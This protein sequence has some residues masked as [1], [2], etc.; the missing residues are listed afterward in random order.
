MFVAALALGCGAGPQEGS[1][2]QAPPVVPQIG[3]KVIGVSSALLSGTAANAKVVVKSTRQVTSYVYDDNGNLVQCTLNSDCGGFALGACAGGYCTETLDIT[4]PFYKANYPVVA[5]SITFPIPCDGALYSVDVFGFASSGLIAPGDANH[6]HTPITIASTACTGSHTATWDPY[7]VPTFAVP[8]IYV[9]LPPPMDKFIVTSSGIGYPWDGAIVV[10]TIPAL[11]GPGSA[12]GNSVTFPAPA[13]GAA[14][15][16]D[17]SYGL[18]PTLVFASDPPLHF[19]TQ[20][21]ATPV[22]A[23]TVTGP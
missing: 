12:S 5:G 4:S 16:F 9:G 23:G 3:P 11:A 6:T 10:T 8:A 2:N 19:A 21:T 13:S 18:D 14:I 15:E 20:T 7:S 22:G 1:S 17:A